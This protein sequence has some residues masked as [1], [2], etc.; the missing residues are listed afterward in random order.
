[1]VLRKSILQYTAVN[2]SAKIKS[3]VSALAVRSD[4]SA[5]VGWHHSAMHAGAIEADQMS[6]DVN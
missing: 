6:D 3:V 1:M 5:F 4:E 2:A